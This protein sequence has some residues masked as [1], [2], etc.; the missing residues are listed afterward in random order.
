MSEKVSNRWSKHMSNKCANSCTIKGARTSK[1]P[2]KDDDGGLSKH[3]HNA[4]EQKYVQKGVQ[5]CGAKIFASYY[6]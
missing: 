4:G 1:S 6:M 5:K 2:C 3:A